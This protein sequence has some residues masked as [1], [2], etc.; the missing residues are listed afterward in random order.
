MSRRP[1][2]LLAVILT[3]SPAVAGEL[4]D[5]KTTPTKAVPGTKASS[6]VILSA[7]NGWHMNK[8]APITIKLAAGAGV[9]VDKPR[10]GRSDAVESTEDHARFEVS[11]TAADPGAKTIDA[12]AS[13]V[14][15]Q[16]AACK[17]VREKVVLSLDIA[18][19]AAPAA[20]PKP[21]AKAK[22]KSRKS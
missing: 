13:F 3:A 17:P 1:L 20:A 15:C 14:I 12:D 4:F 22:G 18:P 16:Q 8:E 7:K 6:S 19:A 21:K 9:T 10:L 5:V 11:F 2:A